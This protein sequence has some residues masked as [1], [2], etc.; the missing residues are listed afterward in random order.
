MQN[1]K[2]TTIKE[3]ANQMQSEINNCE[4][5]ITLTELIDNHS[6][7]LSKEIIDLAEEAFIDFD[8]MYDKYMKIC[9]LLGEEK[10]C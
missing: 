8:K 7:K 10:K 9:E 3:Y 4:A 2:Q 5:L 1:I 6:D